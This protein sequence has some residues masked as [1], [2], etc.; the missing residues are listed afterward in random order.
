MTRRFALVVSDVDGTLVTGDKILTR[1]SIDAVR[2]LHEAGIA[3]SIC[4]S[5]PPFGLSMLIRPL[6]LV[7]PFGAF[8]GGMIVAPDLSPVAAS[9]LSRQA[10]GLAV[11]LLED[12][13]IAVWLF[14]TDAWLV[15]DPAGDHV[16]R[17]IRTIRTKP[18][19]VRS[20]EEHLDKAAKIVGASADLDLVR[21]CEESGRS[22]LAGLA[23]VARSQPYY[24]DFTPPGTNKGRLIELLSGR[25][26]IAREQ[27]AVL[28]DMENDLEMFKR[29]GFGIAMGN[30]ATEVKAAAAATT[31]SNEE[32]GFALAIEREILGER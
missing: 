21:R 7:L 13:G 22:A 30:A 11:A 16:A 2:R 9:Q 32:D 3:F 17:E 19:L 6:A 25:L 20:F 18:T 24:V 4:S 23:M 28:G 27:I 8:N 1:R 10:A 12:R 26:K 14:T 31:L 29:A 15:R 5:R